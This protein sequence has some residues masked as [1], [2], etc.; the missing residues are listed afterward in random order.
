MSTLFKFMS[1]LIGFG[2]VILVI[3][4]FPGFLCDFI[5]RISDAF[6]IAF[7]IGQ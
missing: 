1:S 6:K 2:L 7:N 4:Y 5:Y 3:I